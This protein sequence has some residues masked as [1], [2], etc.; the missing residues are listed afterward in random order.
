MTFTSLA[1]I[2]LYAVAV[3]SGAAATAEETSTAAAE[4][5]TIPARCLLQVKGVKYITGT[6]QFWPTGEGDFVLHGGDYFTYV[7]MSDEDGPNMA[8]AHW[9]ADPSSTHAHSPLG[10]LKRDG[11]CWVSDTVRI[12]AWKLEK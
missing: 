3:G 6:C 8:I 7:F 5:V 4:Q 11:A 2:A 10:K 1:R 12:C 9:N